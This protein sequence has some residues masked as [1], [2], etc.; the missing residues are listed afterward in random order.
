MNVAYDPKSLPLVL[1]RIFIWKQ[2][3]SQTWKQRSVTQ[4]RELHFIKLR[5]ANEYIYSQQKHERIWWW[6]HPDFES[7]FK[8]L[9]EMELRTGGD[10]AEN[11]DLKSWSVL[12][13]MERKIILHFDYN[14]QFIVWPRPT[15]DLT[16][17]TKRGTLLSVIEVV[18]NAS[19]KSSR[20]Y[21]T[22]HEASD[23]TI[24]RLL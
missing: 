1:G 15:G 10:W 17:R 3:E 2:C 13:G 8:R 24:G 18:E 6:I 5:S 4:E 11:N 7:V 9:E 12:T 20:A 19:G 23:E 21:V 22:R 16:S 14:I